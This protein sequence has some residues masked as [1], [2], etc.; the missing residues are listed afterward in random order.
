MLQNRFLIGFASNKI[1]SASAMKS[2]S[3]ILKGEE[4]DS[5]YKKFVMNIH[6]SKEKI[7]R[8]CISLPV[9]NAIFSFQNFYLFVQRLYCEVVQL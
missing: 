3:L 1:V 9:F 6:F 7:M 2:F 4:A 8:K 5:G